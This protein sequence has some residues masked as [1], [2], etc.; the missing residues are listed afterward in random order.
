MILVTCLAHW[1]SACHLL[2]DVKGI[3]MRRET[4]RTGRLTAKPNGKSG[5]N[6]SPVGTQTLKLGSEKESFIY[7]PKNYNPDMPAALAVM[8]H[9]SGG[10]AAHGLSYLHQFADELN[11]IL[12][13][14]ASQ[15]YTWDI[16]ADDSFNKDV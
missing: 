11:I 5:S 16:I 10:I 8:L 15:D 13:A 1:Y 9:G 3:A 6:N 14:P 12:L 7:V 2:G 4:F